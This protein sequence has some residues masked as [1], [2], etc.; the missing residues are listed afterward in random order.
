MYDIGGGGTFCSGGSGVDITLSDSEVGMSYQLY[1]QAGPVA[2]GDPIAG[3]G[4]ALSMG[5]QTVA[6]TYYIE[7]SNN[8]NPSC[9]STMNGTV[10]VIVRSLPVVYDV[11]AVAGTTF[12]SGGSVDIQI[13]NSQTNINYEIYRNGVPTGDIKAGTTGSAV[14]WTV[15]LAGTYTVFA[16]H[17]TIP[18]LYRTDER[19]CHGKPD[20]GSGC[21]VQC[22]WRG[23][24]LFRRQRHGRRS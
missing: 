9:T 1:R 19:E 13:P 24:V 15:N 3:T 8:Q 7:A 20:A 2:V 23:Y 16:S 18:S 4:N 6:G 17:A 5:P 21:Y 11:E 22:D 14:T 12:C 10:V